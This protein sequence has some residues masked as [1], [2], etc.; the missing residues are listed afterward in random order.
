MLRPPPK[1][2]PKSLTM[3]RGLTKA[4]A[5]LRMS[6]VVEEGEDSEEAK[7]RFLFNEFDADGSGELE[8]EEVK[9]LCQRLGLEI[10]TQS[11]DDS[12]ENHTLRKVALSYGLFPYN[13]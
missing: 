8:R 10:D 7:I 13:R 9:A 2:K 3:L 11:L 12:S 5:S 4:M 1:M 6:G